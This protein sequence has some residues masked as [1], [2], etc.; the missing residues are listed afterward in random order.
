ALAASQA[1]GGQG[2]LRD[3]LRA[4]LAGCRLGGDAWCTAGVADQRGAV[5]GRCAAAKRDGVSA[6]VV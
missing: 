2:L 5:A 1:D 4:D 6:A 3:L